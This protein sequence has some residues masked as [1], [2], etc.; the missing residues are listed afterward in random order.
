MIIKIGH[1]FAKA[2]TYYM[3]KHIGHLKERYFKD[4]ISRIVLYLWLNKVLANEGSRCICKVGLTFDQR[5]D[6]ST[7]VDSELGQPTLL[8]GIGIKTM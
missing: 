1:N 2:E 8:S 4:T 6:D 7:D 5:Q 3:H